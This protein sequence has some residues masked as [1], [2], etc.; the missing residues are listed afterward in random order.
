MVVSGGV[1]DELNVVGPSVSGIRHF[2]L[3]SVV[4]MVRN[5]PIEHAE[6]RW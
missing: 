2:D 3:L 1:N 6:S 5:S 4:M